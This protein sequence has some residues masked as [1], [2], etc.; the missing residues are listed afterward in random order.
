MKTIPSLS[1]T[2]TLE[3]IK[4]QWLT[5]SDLKKLACVGNNRVAEIKK[6][7]IDKLHEE[8]KNYYL[9]SGLLPTD[10]VVDYLKINIK[11]LEK[12]SNKK[13]ERKNVSTL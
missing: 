4:K 10:R 1:A 7:I 13:E 2:E 5:T 8:D 9:P 11:Y 12:I 3:I 6:A